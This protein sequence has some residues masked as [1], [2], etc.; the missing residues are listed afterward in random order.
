MPEV[1]IQ[2]Q[3]T[4]GECSKLLP[5]LF[6]ISNIGGLW[7]IYMWFHC[8]PLY[9]D[10]DTHQRALIEIVIFNAIT[11]L[12]L[13]CYV[14]CIL[15]HPG[16]IPSKEE[17]PQWEY[18]PQDGRAGGMDNLM[19]ETKKSGDR[20]QCKWCAK[21]KPDRCHHCRVCRMCI[22]KMDHH[23]PWIYNCVG[24]R[25]HKYFFLLLFYSALATNFIAWTML[26]SVKHAIE[27]PMPFASMFA[28]LFGETLA[29]F[30]GILVT[31]F[32]GFHIWLM[33]KGMTTIEFCEKSSKK[34]GAYRSPYDKGV[35]G[36]I[37]AVLGDWVI[38]WLLP[39]APPWEGA[40]LYF[41]EEQLQAQESTYLARDL[42][43]S[44]GT[45]RRKSQRG[46][47]RSK[48]GRSHHR[49]SRQGPSCAGTGSAPG[50]FT[51]SVHSLGDSGSGRSQ[52]YGGTEA[53]YDHYG[54]KRRAAKDYASLCP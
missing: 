20:R 3:R 5:V 11:F 31:M 34:G 15:V 21:F 12:L 35:A 25:N 30:M 32:F 18:V 48:H 7:F 6:V 9:L 54:G 2:E 14:Q 46:E 42:E 16:T 40:G 39:L 17:D 47:H 49:E 22:L 1:E 36:N 23:C 52:G 24:F 29:A 26:E 4:F 41:K 37:R 27:T 43:T 50:L 38:L 8:Y 19:Q 13:L 53:V 45:G 10:P 28:I 51:G 44:R 33:L